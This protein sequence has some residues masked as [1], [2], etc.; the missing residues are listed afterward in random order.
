[1]Y[2][3]L[4]TLFAD[5]IGKLFRRAERAMERGSRER[6]VPGTGRLPGDTQMSRSYEIFG[7]ATFVCVNKNR[8]AR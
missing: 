6:G 5:G 3:R 1:M 2:I 4:G 7:L 8:L